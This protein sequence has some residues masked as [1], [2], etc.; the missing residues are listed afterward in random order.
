MPLQTIHFYCP[1]YKRCPCKAGYCY[2]CYYCYYCCC[3]YYYYYYYH[4]HHQHTPLCKYCCHML[5]LQLMPTK[6][7]F[8]RAFSKA[9]E[10]LS[11][12]SRDSGV[13]GAGGFGRACSSGLRSGWVQMHV[14][15][16][17][18]RSLQPPRLFEPRLRIPHLRQ[19]KPGLSQRHPVFCTKLFRNVSRSRDR[20][21][22]RQ[23]PPQGHSGSGARR[24]LSEGAAL[25]DGRLIRVHLRPSCA[26]AMMQKVGDDQQISRPP[27]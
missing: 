24:S 27:I 7:G 2:Y 22:E 17:P 26:G 14:S 10:G 8:Y 21:R 12:A 9:P 25:P 6:T 3:C 16:R 15:R 11:C 19:R 1:C 23:A 5:L 18:P 20:N 4:H 13:F